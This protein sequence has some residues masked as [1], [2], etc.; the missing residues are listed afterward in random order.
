MSQNK[1]WL[2]LVPIFP[3]GVFVYRYLPID[4]K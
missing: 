1:P 4:E 2:G 3:G